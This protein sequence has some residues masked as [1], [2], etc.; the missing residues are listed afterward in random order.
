MN[1]LAKFLPLFLLISTPVFANP[2][3]YQQLKQIAGVQ[4][5]FN[6]AHQ[7]I[8]SR[9]GDHASLLEASKRRQVEVKHRPDHVIIQGEINTLIHSSKLR[10]EAAKKEPQIIDHLLQIEA[11][12]PATNHAEINRVK[13]EAFKHLNPEDFEKHKSMIPFFSHPDG[14][15]IAANI[16]LKSNI[17]LR[18]KA[19]LLNLALDLSTEKILM[20]EFQKFG[21]FDHR[22]SAEAVTVEAGKLNDIHISISELN[23]IAKMT[24]KLATAVEI[25]KLVP[26]HGAK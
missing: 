9:E 2:S 25:A 4:T 22:V 23:S 7:H 17:P 6:Q 12:L 21:H 24:N 11:H 3:R 8:A 19:K 13:T 26:T 14:A 16:V 10:L 5:I 20:P 1:G 15:H 18:D